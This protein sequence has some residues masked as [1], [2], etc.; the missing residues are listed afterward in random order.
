MIDVERLLAD[1][2][3]E[4]SAGGEADPREYLSR[5]SPSDQ[6][7]LAALIDAY[8]AR[9][10]RQEF[11]EAT[12][13]GSSAERT[14]DE[15]ERAIAGQAGLWPALLPRLRDRAGLKRSELIERL[16]AA[17]GV[18]DRKDKVAGYYHEMEQGLL[19]AQGV[20][21]RVLD[22]LGQLIGETRTALREAGRALTPP[23]EGRL[24]APAAF[25]RR[26]SAEPAEAPAPGAQQPPAAE[27]DEVDEL[28]RGA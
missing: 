26:A 16:A 10:P 13:R 8:L 2:I 27:G 4:H 24:A 25:A 18:S 3:A 6:R 11:D 1:Y 21:D 14:V 22:A 12:F 9:A 20:S 28:F 23:S 7:E 5:A 19:P 17:L 15:L